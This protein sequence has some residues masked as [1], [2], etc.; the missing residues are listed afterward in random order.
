M[1]EVPGGVKNFDIEPPLGESDPAKPTTCV[2]TDQEPDNVFAT[3]E[4]SSPVRR[5]GYSIG[6]NPSRSSSRQNSPSPGLKSPAHESPIKFSE[7]KDLGD[8]K[9]KIS[10]NDF[11]SFSPIKAD[12]SQNLTGP[13]EG[14]PPLPNKN[15]MSQIDTDEYP[16][17][18]NLVV[19]GE[20]HHYSIGSKDSIG[21]EIAVN[22]K[23]LARLRQQAEVFENKISNLKRQSKTAEKKTAANKFGSNND[24]NS[25]HHSVVEKKNL[26][27]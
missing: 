10:K 5:R 3:P 23:E 19:A 1:D 18:T 11:D 9:T 2:E 6:R 22:E 12:D 7:T 8:T 15:I 14:A 24:K 16:N 13:A 20:F 25:G 17:S 21:R 4:Q 26:E 27:F